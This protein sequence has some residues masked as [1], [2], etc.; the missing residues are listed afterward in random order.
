MRVR[1]A[2][3]RS[4]LALWQAEYVKARLLSLPDNLEVVLVPMVTEGDK[5]LGQ[6]LAAAGG[7]GL[8]L[9]E[10]EHAMQ[11][12]KA[13]IAVHSMKD[14]PTELPDGFALSAILARAP[15]ADAIVSNHHD[16]LASLPTGAIVGTSSLRRR[17]QLLHARP[18]LQV[19]DLRG[20][21]NT[22]LARLDAGDFD[23]IILAA[24]GLERLELHDRIRS[25]LDP[26]DWVPAAGQGAIGIEQV[27]SN[28][29]VA[30]LM[31]ALDDPCTARCVN[32][33]RAVAHALGASCHLPVAAYAVETEGQ[34]DLQGLVGDPDGEQILTARATGTD[35]TELGS[36]VADQLLT[37]GAKAILAKLDSDG[38]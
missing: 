22:R 36:A 4:P 9:K 1:I 32:A 29:P 12:S 19:R 10:L 34:I 33:E 25:R 8:F 18:D 23:A 11:D 30:S 20:N 35:L 31:R 27:A 15:V 6:S 28:E 16:T 5:K 24:A 2:T 13:D 21:V 14:V 17:A 3:R 37:Q 26:P 7:K 38:G